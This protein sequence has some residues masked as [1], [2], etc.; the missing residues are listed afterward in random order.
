[1]SRAS[2]ILG[3]TRAEQVDEVVAIEAV[4][5]GRRGSDKGFAEPFQRI[6]ATFHVREVGGEEHDL[7]ARLGDQPAS[8]F[9]GI[10]GDAH[11]TSD[12]FAG[13]RRKPVQPLSF[14]KKAA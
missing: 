3:Q 6:A 9:M 1:M 8:V 11:L 7:L 12:D 14:L 4:D 10:G 5:R 13:F 2:Q